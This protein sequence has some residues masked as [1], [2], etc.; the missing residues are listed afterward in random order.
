MLIGL[1]K[2]NTWHAGLLYRATGNGAEALLA[3]GKNNLRFF[4]PR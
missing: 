2:I 4:L 1:I 3:S